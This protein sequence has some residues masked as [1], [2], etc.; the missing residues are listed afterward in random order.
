MSRRSFPRVRRV[1]LAT[2]DLV[3]AA[4]GPLGGLP[5]VGRYGLPVQ[6]VLL[7]GA[8]G[9]GKST[10]AR[11][12]L[13]VWAAGLVLVQWVDVDALWLHQPWRV[14]EPM[15]SMLRANLGAVAGNA[16][17]AGVEVLLLTWVFQSAEMHDLVTALLP[18]GVTTMSVQLRASAKTWRARFEADPDRPPVNDF[19]K[20]RYAGAQTSPADHVVLT[21]DL[22]VVGVARRV[23]DLVNLTP[24]RELRTAPSDEAAEGNL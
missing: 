4:D 1:A 14:D 7:G 19:F 22:D 23:A 10:V 13:D 5:C 12:L 3:A 6:V 24:T 11:R 18:E 8:P 20:S 17:E 9:V 15:T 16:C 2:R 21:D